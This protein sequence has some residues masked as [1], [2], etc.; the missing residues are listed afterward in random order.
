MYTYNKKMRERPKSVRV[1][2][3]FW[4]ALGFT[5]V[6]ALVWFAFIPGKIASISGAATEI[7][8]P[9]G[10][11][12]RVLGSIRDNLSASLGNSLADLQQEE[13]ANTSAELVVETVASS[14]DPNV[15]DF[16]TMIGIDETMS[17][18]DIEAGYDYEYDYDY[19]PEYSDP[20]SVVSTSSTLQRT[21]ATTTPTTPRVVLIGTSS[22]ATT[23][24]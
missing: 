11:F 16:S 13:V 4:Y 12:A 2:Y 3:A 17:V 8:E 1:L 23:T 10:N 19:D 5:A 21:I 24:Q 20:S 22:K 14:S 7:E 18:E 9:A 15:L 6:I